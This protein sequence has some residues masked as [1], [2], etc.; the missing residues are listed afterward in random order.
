MIRVG[1]AAGRPTARG[2]VSRLSATTAL[3]VAFVGLAVAWA[4]MGALTYRLATAPV[5]TN[6]ILL[7][8]LDGVLSA[9]ANIDGTA[10]FW[11]G[12]GTERIALSWP[13][14]YAARGSPLAPAL[15]WA[16]AGSH[17]RL[18]VYDETGRRVAEVGQR[19]TMGGGLMG[20]E[21]Q[22]IVGCSGFPRFWGVGKV[23]GA[24]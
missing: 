7:A 12:N 13:W 20:D 15:G 14:G 9:Q 22:S 24:R 11:V 21:V 23:I 16:H 18:A 1:E 3:T 17:S 5:R 4:G 19:V 6:L 8:R 2:R 10:C